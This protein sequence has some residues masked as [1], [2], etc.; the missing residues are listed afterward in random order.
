MMV[1]L[2]H[3]AVTTFE[4]RR[5]KI[6]WLT[7]SDFLV[8]LGIYLIP[9]WRRYAV[10]PAARFCDNLSGTCAMVMMRQAVFC[11]KAFVISPY[12]RWDRWSRKIA[13]IHTAVKDLLTAPFHVGEWW[14]ILPWCRNMPQHPMPSWRTVAGRSGLYF[15]H[16][17]Y[18]TCFPS[19]P[20]KLPPGR[21][22]TDFR[23]WI[24][25]IALLHLRLSHKCKDG[26]HRHDGRIYIAAFHP[27]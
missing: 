1:I 20:W 14:S 5:W 22:F 11:G 21:L 25:F 26:L 19:Q 23:W 16:F 4:G 8:A 27:Y 7:L 18:P 10:S 2:S 13:H 6:Y 24:T 3:V 15:R 12:L 17:E 9:H